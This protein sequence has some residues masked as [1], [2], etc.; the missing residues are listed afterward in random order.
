MKIWNP[1]LK[2]FKRTHKWMDEG[3]AQAICP[4]N[5]F[6]VRGIM[7]DAD[8]MVNGKEPH[9]QSCLVLNCLPL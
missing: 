1:E 9:Q 3:G 2:F 6:K 8:G 5:F 7:K 4:L